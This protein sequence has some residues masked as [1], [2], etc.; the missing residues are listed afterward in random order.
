MN[1]IQKIQVTK[2]VYFLT[3]ADND[4]RI[5]C[6]CP[7]DCVK[8][9]MKRGLIVP[10]ERDGVTFETGPNAILL[11]DIMLQNGVMSNLAEFP[12][13]QMLYRQGMMLPDH[14]NN[15]GTK[16]LI[17]G[18]ADQVSAQ[19]EY[20]YRGNYGLV[21]EQEI[22]AAG[23]EREQARML[24]RMKLKF[25]FGRIQDSGE[26][27]DS[28]VIGPDAVEIRGGVS[29]HRL[30]RNL[31]EFSYDGETVTVDLNLS[32]SEN[33]E[34]PFPL[35]MRNIPREYF[36]VIHSGEG[37]GWDENR[38]CMSSILMYQGR[39]YLIDAGP[40]ILYNLRALGIG[41]NEIEGIFHTHAHDDHFAGLT[42]IIRSD[43]KIK[44]FATPLV[45][46]S[47]TKK[48]TALLS[49]D[50]NFF[51]HY[52]EVHDLE[53]DQWN[54]VAGMDVRPI[55]S[56][57]PV[58]T[59]I[60]VFR[61]L[62]EEGY[63]TY[64]HLADIASFNVLGG[65]VTR[66][67]TAIG[68]SPTLF[69]QVKQAYMEPADLKKIDIG[70]GLIHGAAIDFKGDQS[71]KIILAHKATE[72]TDTEKEIGSGAP[73]GTVD[74][75][76]PNY[77]NYDR[78]NAFHYLSSY[79][80][81]V[82]H[83]R[84]TILLNNPVEAINPETI[85]IREDQAATCVYLVLTG[86]VEMIQSEANI[87]TVLAPGAMIGEQM[88]LYGLASRETYRARNFVQALKI[89]CTLFKEFID[90]N[91]LL[92]AIGTLEEKRNFLRRS[93]LFGESLSHWTQ[94]TICQ[95]MRDVTYADGEGFARTDSDPLELGI[96]R[97]GCLERVNGS[98]ADDDFL[99]ASEFFGETSALF[100]V[101]D[102]VPYRAHEK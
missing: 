99:T 80:P 97:T 11:S 63:R 98:R 40:N 10:V 9:L 27:L 77:Q 74:V 56:P 52:F 61:A 96:V 93:W 48:L 84:L 88:A 8:H 36:A 23:V 43:H 75:L 45:R 83:H 85:L 91:E 13:L 50:E 67:P 33:Y 78:R 102:T 81:G 35:G 18:A 30:E 76:I 65:M 3:F 37:D 62:W 82:S 89:P 14:P 2:G 12:V 42:D 17:I 92:D 7:A 28:L 5:L 57:H 47:V 32:S 22:M 94:N 79:F 55:M 1:K 39:I 6:G 58:E 49:T 29:V 44:Y 68:I 86:D 95:A 24:M 71:T 19:M 38:P 25:A 72:L 41:I 69:G 87:R 73:Y 26:M 90:R 100:H 59:S 20:I 51:Q 70:G 54:D 66:D 16:P 53:Y 31:F 4:L 21:S 15:T 64:A 34:V 101:P 60:F 46:A